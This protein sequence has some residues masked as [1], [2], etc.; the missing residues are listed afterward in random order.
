MYVGV[1]K[2]RWSGGDEGD[3]DGDGD[4]TQ[5]E[6]C[7]GWWVSGGGRREGRGVGRGSLTVG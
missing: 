2:R 5:S 3:G 7:G 4:G 1:C 6:E